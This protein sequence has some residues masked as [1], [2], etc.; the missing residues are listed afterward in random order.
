M[1]SLLSLKGYFKFG[2]INQSKI[3]L[4]R[5]SPLYLIHHYSKIFFLH[6][7][8]LCTY[9]WLH[10]VYLLQSAVI[11]KTKVFKILLGR[12]WHYRLWNFKSRDTNLILNYWILRIGLTGSLS[13]LQKS[14]F[15]KLI[16]DFFRFFSDFF[17]SNL[18][19][20]E[21]K[22]KKKIWVF[23]SLILCHWSWFWH[24]K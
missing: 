24:Q 3:C 7:M 5:L 19:V 11:Y 20:F 13:S 14:E 9:I 2:L 21:P 23:F 15:F 22:V 1:I 17:R 8:Y 4:L 12:L 6:V 18:F 16:M 10:V